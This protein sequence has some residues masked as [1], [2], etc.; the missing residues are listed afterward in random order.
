MFNLGVIAN[1]NSENH[2]KKWLYI[3]D[4]SYRMLI[5]GGFRSGKGNGL[6]NLIEEQDSY[7]LIDK[8]DLYAKDINEP[9][10]Q[11]L[12]KKHVGRCRSKRFKWSKSICRIFSIYV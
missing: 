9:K 5:I 4:Y 11:L 12:I 8:I 3:P 2:S 7:E 1:E 10:Y 6:L